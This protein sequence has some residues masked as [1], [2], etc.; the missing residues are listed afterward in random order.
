MKKQN[1][2]TKKLGDFFTIVFMNSS[3]LIYCLGAVWGQRKKVLG[4]FSDTSLKLKML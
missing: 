2:S 3:Q 1:H 4:I